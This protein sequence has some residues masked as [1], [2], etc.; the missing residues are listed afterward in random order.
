MAKELNIAALSKT[1]IRNIRAGD[2]S[3]LL[4]YCSIFYPIETQ[5]IG[6][7]DDLD[8]IGMD[9]YLPLLN[10]TNDGNISSQQDMVQ[11]FSDYFQYFKIWLS[12]Q[13]S[14]ASS[15]PVVSTEVE[16]P[17]SLA[18]LAIPSAT[19]PIQCFGNYSANFTLQDMGFKA[20]ENNSEVFNET[21]ILW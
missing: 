5:K 12:N 14:N 2:Y 17:S 20:L 3:G 6:F 9:F 8:F 4:T 11:R 19:P 18:G 10:I 15:K 13:S 1:L 7:W 16:Y 21:I